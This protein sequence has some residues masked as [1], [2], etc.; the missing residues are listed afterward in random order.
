MQAAT[1]HTAQPVRVLHITASAKQGGGPEHITQLIKW[2]DDSVINYIA[3][4]DEPPYAGRFA[5][6][7]GKQRILTIPSRKFSLISLLKMISFIRKN[8]I[9]IIHSHGK[10][11]GIFGRPAA[12]ATG[13]SSVHTFHGIH[14]Q[15]GFM[16]RHIYIFIERLLSKMTKRTI[17]VSEG[18]FRTAKNLLFTTDSQCTI[19]ENG[20]TIPNI[21]KHASNKGGTFVIIHMTRFDTAKNSRALVPIAV[22]LERRGEL[23]NF[24]FVVLGDG[25]ERI[26]C[27]NDAK[28]AQVDKAFHF[29]GYQDNPRAW[30]RGE[31]DATM[32]GRAGCLLSTSRWEGLPLALLEAMSEGVPVIASD[33]I[34]NNDIVRQGKSGW[35]YP[36]DAPEKAAE[37]CI[38]LKNSTAL[39][40]SMS[41]EA[42]SRARSR[43]SAERMSAETLSVYRDLIASS[44]SNQHPTRG[45]STP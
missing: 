44:P 42:I 29:A 21:V 40:K 39:Q 31:A 10:G 6:L 22:E 9:R 7:V 25:E 30:L 14:L 28:T 35:L 15:Y 8:K 41:E 1:P 16:L 3:A 20:V 2:L 37:Y 11:A 32:D 19:I 43:Y 38:L 45:E 12:L 24:R 33:V 23:E 17:C 5:L 36:L 4:P 18:E 26:D 34:G 13:T 27:T